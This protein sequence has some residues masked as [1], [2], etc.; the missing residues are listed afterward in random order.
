MAVRGG[1]QGASQRL[2]TFVVFCLLVGTLTVLLPQAAV[3]TTVS[4][5]FDR[6]NGALGSNWTTV[7][8]AAAPQIVSDSL[9]VGTASA[10]NSAYWSASTFGNDQFA[11]A[12]M[13]D[14]SGTQYGPGIAVRLSSTKG[15][16]LWYGNSPNTVS[17]WKMGSSTS[18]STLKQSGP[19]TISPATDV[20]RIQV[21]GSTISGY[22]NGNLVVQATDTSIKSGSPGVWL[23]YSP[24]QI[25]NWSG[26]DVAPYSVGGTVSGLSGTVVLQD[27]GS[28]NLTVTASGAFTFPTT[29]TT[30]SPYNV[31]VQ[32]SRPAGQTSRGSPTERAPSDRPASPTSPSPARQWPRRSRTVSTGPTGLSAPTGRRFRARRRPRLSVDLSAWER[33]ARLT[34]LTGVPARSAMTSSRRRRCRTAPEL[35]TGRESPSG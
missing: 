27:N 7:S 23:Y 2:V 29:L 6:A 20:W 15:Y 26:G 18:W 33:P 35:S 17:L 9:T 30:G 28:D 11:Q 8:G 13:P 4:D 1:S 16:F 19:L 24:D 10:L 12:T 32:A 22:Q 3:A 5:S 21:V 14:S 34:A 25:D 31:T